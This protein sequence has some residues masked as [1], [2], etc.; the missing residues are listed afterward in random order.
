MFEDKFA[1]PTALAE[2]KEKLDTL[3]Q[4]NSQTCE[5]YLSAKVAYMS[6]L[7]T[8][9]DAEKLI[10]AKKGLLPEFRSQV[11]AADSLEKLVTFALE[12][13]RNNKPPE[14]VNVFQKKFTGE[15]FYCRK[16]GHREAEC[17]RNERMPSP[18]KID[19]MKPWVQSSTEKA[20]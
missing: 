5:D 15:C 2:F 13:D 1:S 8:M 16:I 18:P 20:V 3:V 11:V 10:S 12:I 6:L 7:P 4:T 9:S 14:S 17:R 19:L